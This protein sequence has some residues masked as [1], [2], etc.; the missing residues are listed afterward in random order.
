MKERVELTD[1]ILKE[2]KKHKHGIW[3][4]KLARNLEEP[5]S[6]VHKYV[7]MKDYAGKYLEMKKAPQ[8][9]GGHLIVKLKEIKK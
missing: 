9:L 8:E 4:R 5:V 7:M 2:I 6:T 3:I 1:K